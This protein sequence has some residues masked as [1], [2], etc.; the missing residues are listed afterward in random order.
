SSAGGMHI[1]LSVIPD[2]RGRFILYAPDGMQA[3]GDLSEAREEAVER[4]RLIAESYARRMR[5]DRFSLDIHVRDRSAPTSLE[6]ELYID[7]SIL[8][9]M[10]Y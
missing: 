5:Y 6:S 9:F 1:D 2:N 3:F 10:R 8:A 7:T 4:S